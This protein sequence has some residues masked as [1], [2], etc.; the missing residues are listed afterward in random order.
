M[1]GFLA[2]EILPWST[3]VLAPSNKRP[4]SMNTW[5]TLDSFSAGMVE[6]E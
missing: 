1:T 2:R 4:E 3:L 6:Q 5:E